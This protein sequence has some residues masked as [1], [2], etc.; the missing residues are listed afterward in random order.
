MKISVNSGLDYKR[1]AKKMN[2][3]SMKNK[4]KAFYIFS[5]ISVCFLL[6]FSFFIYSTYSIITNPSKS[7][8]EKGKVVDAQISDLQSSEGFLFDKTK[9]TM[10]ILKLENSNLLLTEGLV[11]YYMDK[12]LDAKIE[13]YSKFSDINFRKESMKKY[14]TEQGQDFYYKKSTNPIDN[15]QL[16]AVKE[17]FLFSEDN[18]NSEIVKVETISKNSYDNRFL[19]PLILASLS[20]FL[21]VGLLYFKIG[22]HW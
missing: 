13:E 12:N 4:D 6:I 10:V 2:K 8:Y 20:L 19:E 7:G 21:L 18:K 9:K 5:F 14:L 15:T 1:I 22:R 11:D 16:L 3:N 17:S